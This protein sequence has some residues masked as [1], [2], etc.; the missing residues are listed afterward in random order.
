MPPYFNDDCVAIFKTYSD[1]QRRHDHPPRPTLQVWKQTAGKSPNTESGKG[2][3][4]NERM[5]NLPGLPGLWPPKIPGAA[6]SRGAASPHSSQQEAQER[7]GAASQ[8]R[9]RW[10]QYSRPP[11]GL[12][13]RERRCQ[14]HKEPTCPVGVASGARA[15]PAGPPVAQRGQYE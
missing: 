13:P 15:P 9:K 12:T 3:F 14:D 4:R 2:L 7:A 1:R 11:A 6:G 10:S 5:T 8:S